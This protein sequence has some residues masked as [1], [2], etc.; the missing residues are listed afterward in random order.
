MNVQAGHLR[1]ASIPTP[2]EQHGFQ[3]SAEATLALVKQAEE[4]YESGLALVER[5]VSALL[6]FRGGPSFTRQDLGPPPGGFPRAIE[7]RPRHLLASPAFVSPPPQK[8]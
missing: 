3:T 7:I 2:S 5:A 1:D 8:R 6:L 4:Q